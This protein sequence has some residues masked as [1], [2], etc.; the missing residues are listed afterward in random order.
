MISSSLSKRKMSVALFCSDWGL[1]SLVLRAEI[2]EHR[3]GS[4]SF[5][6][7]HHV[8]NILVQGLMAGGRTWQGADEEEVCCWRLSCESIY[9]MDVGHRTW[10][11]VTC[12]FNF[13]QVCVCV[14]NI[15]C[16]LFGCWISIWWS[17]LSLFNPNIGHS[18]QHFELLLL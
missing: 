15:I 18:H 3:F 11:T 4:K 16:A 7:Q 2:K 17:H 9:C 8:H 6:Q 12:D 14:C 13:E 1:F 10:V 5:M